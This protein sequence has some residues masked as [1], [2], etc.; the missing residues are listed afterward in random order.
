MCAS[1]IPSTAPHPNPMICVASTMCARSR[2]VVTPPTAPHPN[3]MSGVASTMCA[4]SRNVIHVLTQA[5]EWRSID[6]ACQVP[7]RLSSPPFDT[8]PTPWVAIDHLCKR[9]E[10]YHRNTCCLATG[11]LNRPATH[12]SR[13]RGRK[14]Q[15][16]TSNTCQSIRD[17]C[18]RRNSQQATSP[19]GFLLS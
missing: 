9:K 2:G 11:S 13:R 17:C 15:R 3:P 4:S 5:H 18:A 8:I 10:R 19:L 16:E 14:R 6:H 12:N 1:A 7:E